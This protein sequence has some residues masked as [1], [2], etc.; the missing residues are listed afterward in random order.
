MQMKLYALFFLTLKRVVGKERGF[1]R[2][3]IDDRGNHHH[4]FDHVIQL[5]EEMA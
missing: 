3:K 4:A 2:I 5:S 1:G